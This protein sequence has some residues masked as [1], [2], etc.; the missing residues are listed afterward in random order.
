MDRR[1]GE[2]ETF[3]RCLERASWRAGCVGVVV[4]VVAGDGR[5]GRLVGGS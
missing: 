5:V 4:G 1:C 3:Y 2:G